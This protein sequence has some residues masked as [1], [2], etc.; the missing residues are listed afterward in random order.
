VRRINSHHAVGH[1]NLPSV[2]LFIWRLKSYSIQSAPAYCLEEAGSH[3]YTF[4][5]LG[6]DTQ[7]YTHPE[8]KTESA[9]TAE[10]LNLPTP[11]R[12]RA[13]EQR[14]I[15]GGTEQ[16]QASTNYYGQGKSLLIWANHWPTENAPQP[17]PR[18]L[19]I[20]ADLSDWQYRPPLGRIAVDPE[21]GR[22]AFPPSQL[23]KK[24][25]HVM[26]Y[27]GFS[28]D[29]GGGEY[30]RPQSQPAAYELYRVGEREVFKHIHD[31]LQHW[32]QQA[33]S[34]AII[35]ITDNGIYTEQISIELAEQQSLQL[36]AA[37]HVRPIIRLLDWHTTLPDALTI[38]ML[39]G[40]R[41]T[42][43]GLLI[44]GRGV[45]VIRPQTGKTP[46]ATCPAE[47]AIRHC[48]LVPGW[49][50]HPNCDPKRPAEPSLELNNVRA[51]V[52]IE[53]SIIGSIQVNEDAVT[54]DPIPVQITDS[55]LDATRHDRE[56]FG[57]PGRVVA[58]A[59]L[60]IQRS[61]VLGIVEVHAIKL[62]ENC[63]FTGCVNVA[64]RQMGCMRFCYVPHGCR[65]PRRY[66][67]Q[68]DLVEQAV[69]AAV[70]DAAQRMTP[71]PDTKQLAGEINAARLRERKRVHPR[72]NSERYGTPTYCQLADVCA[73]EI[74]HGADDESEMGVFH[75][76]FQPQREANLRAR[77]DEYVPAG[78]DAGI[79]Y[80]S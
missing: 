57:A 45:R 35:E 47:L 12:R 78:A 79:I 22:I 44:T 20:P 40:S 75:D 17:I 29:I 80:A 63:I 24:R 11:I 62:A 64:R 13:F 43:D 61:T 72:F 67:C 1:Y 18:E 73:D 32:Q 2:G 39:R 53:H 48:T 9:H 41:F 27:Y 30:D 59:V 5:A 28:A 25:V 14:V 34:N 16:R 31:A 58:H 74:K 68:P 33:P 8:P 15:V 10:E 26:Y 71:P 7:L 19:L 77:L 55:I 4:S 36:R 54:T 60:T 70:R 69:E 52:R 65:T 21:S 76:L 3:C 46:A 42:L 51:R 38:T 66:N 6:N 49:A 37:R 50:L 23:P 56:A